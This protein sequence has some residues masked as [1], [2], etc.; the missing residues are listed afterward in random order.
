[1]SVMSAMEKE[2]NTFENE[3]TYW[4]LSEK[5]KVDEFDAKYEKAVEKVRAEL[6]GRKLPMVINGEE[7]ETDQWIEHHSPADRR[8][9]L[10]KIPKATKEHAVKAIEAARAGFDAWR[11]TPWQERADLLDKTADLYVENFYEL[12]AIMSFEC[13]KNRFETS[14]D[15]DEAIDFLRFY[16]YKMRQFEGFEMEMGRPYPNERC[17]S[18]M[19]PYGVFSVICPF[20]FPVA[21]TTGMTAGALVTGNTAIMKPSMKG[22]LAGFR[23]YQLMREAGIPG[24]ALQFIL[25]PNVA[26]E[27]TSNKGVDGIVFTGSKDVGFKVQQQMNEHSP[28]T[29][30]IMEMGGK[31]PI[32]VT[33]NADLDKAVE[34][35]YRSAFGAQG[36]KCSAGSRLLV[37]K[38]IH[39]EFVRRLLERTRDTMVAQPWKKEAFMGPVIEE[40]KYEEYQ[41]VARR[42]KADGEILTGGEVLKEDELAHGYYVSPMV[43]SG[44]P[45]DHEFFNKELFLPITMVWQVD[46]IGDAVKAANAVDFGLTAG[47][48]TEDQKEADYFF[49]N[50]QAGTT[51][52]NRKSG[53]STAAVVNGQAFGGWKH[54]GSTG[55]GAGG[56][57]Y[58]QQFMREQSQTRV[59]D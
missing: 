32:I 20:N 4:R 41:E 3:H 12:C 50:V 17:R 30:V 57:Y 34:G 24:S 37:D 28:S 5:G 9:L 54:S 38:K 39:D 48:F 8:L 47:I 13:G 42:V 25:G 2:F 1:M 53:G 26:R 40:S 49:E 56:R 52:L 22:T 10:A 36:Q 44:L 7:V 55:R 46:G 58:L 18:V 51:Y 29:P 23:C 6:L 31:N 35:C 19:K 45:R 14:I 21:I 16:A 59:V 27:L 43:A 33:A 11:K 15:V